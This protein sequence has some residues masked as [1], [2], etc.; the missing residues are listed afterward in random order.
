[1]ATDPN[2][3]L[4]LVGTSES[5]GKR[6][7]VSCWR[8]KGQCSGVDR[9]K[10]RSTLDCTLKTHIQRPLYW[11]LYTDFTHCTKPLA[12]GSVG[13][14]S[15][16]NVRN[17]G[18]IPGL[19]RS[20]GRGHGNPLQCSCLEN[21]YGQRWLADYSP[22]GHKKLDTAEHLSTKARHNIPLCPLFNLIFP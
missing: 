9:S 8:V 1:M 10:S 17:L 15:V 13:K 12:V 6:L 16:C 14:E 7:C 19:G 20:P 4:N 5:V 22:W 21:P 11:M 2:S 3:F 18:L